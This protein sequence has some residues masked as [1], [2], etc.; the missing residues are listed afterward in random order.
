MFVL[1]GGV[2]GGS[3]YGAWPGLASN[4]LDDGDLFI[5]TGHD[6]RHVLAELISKRLANGASLAQVFTNFAPAPLG[7]FMT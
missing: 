7:I 5:P 3:I 6:Q 1:G 4:Q 2:N